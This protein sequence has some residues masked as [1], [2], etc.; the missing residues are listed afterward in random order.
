MEDKIV[1]EEFLNKKYRYLTLLQYTHTTLIS[2]KKKAENIEEEFRNSIRELAN[3][4]KDECNEK[5]EK[6]ELPKLEDEDDFTKNT[7]EKY[8]NCEAESEFD[9]ELNCT[10][11]SEKEKFIRKFYYNL[12]KFIHPDKT[13]DASKFELFPLCKSSV[14]KNILYKLV[15][16]AHKFNIEFELE[17]QSY[18]YLD[19][20]IAEINN[21]IDQFKNTYAYQWYSEKDEQLKENII[22]RYL[23]EKIFL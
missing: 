23:N 15:L 19:E 13:D 20:E 21:K 22:I 18:K 14:D 12:S 11:N 6:G 16:I 2:E 10:S 8:D 4:T 5:R 7:R 1:N 3:K 17:E 9:D